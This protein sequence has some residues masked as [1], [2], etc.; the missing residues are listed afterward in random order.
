MPHCS[1]HFLHT[2]P[3]IIACER[4]QLQQHPLAASWI[5]MHERCLCC[6]ATAPLNCWAAAELCSLISISFIIAITAAGTLCACPCRAAAAAAA[7]QVQS[8]CAAVQ[9][10]SCDNLST[11]CRHI[12]LEVRLLLPL[13]ALLLPKRL[14]GAE[15]FSSRRAPMD[16][17]QYQLPIR[18]SIQQAVQGPT[19]PAEVAACA[20]VQ[21]AIQ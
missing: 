14:P 6:V 9:V 2:V 10:T 16:P 13:R 18:H 8:W 1:A 20:C 11:A 3:H 5:P 15:R 12:S 21:P 17:R 4:L 19:W 7:D